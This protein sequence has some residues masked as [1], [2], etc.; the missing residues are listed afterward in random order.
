AS[1]VRPLFDQHL[2]GQ[3]RRL[4]ECAVAR[5]GQRQERGLLNQPAIQR[6]S[7]NPP[8]GLGVLLGQIED[9]CAWC[10]HSAHV[11]VGKVRHV[12][13]E[14]SEGGRKELASKSQCGGESRMLP[15]QQ[16][17]ST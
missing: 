10:L 3:A 17:Q 6:P 7:I 5:T 4:G 15:P 9:V 13:A 12:S 2:A 14:P 16:A 11:T 1:P 8:N